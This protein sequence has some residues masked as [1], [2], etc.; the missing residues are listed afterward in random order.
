MA[1]PSTRTQTLYRLPTVVPTPE[2]MFDALGPSSVELL[3]SIAADVQQID[4]AGSPALWLSGQFEHAVASWC[5]HAATTTGL[6]VSYPSLQAAGLLLLA[7]DD[8]VYALGYGCGHRLIPDE[9]KDQSFGLRFAVRRLDPEQVQDLVRRL[10]GAR[11]RTDATV[12][13]GGLPVW[14][15]G[16]QEHAEI[17]RRIGGRTRDLKITFSGTDERPVKVEG[18][19]GLSMRFGVRPGD[20]VSD[21]REVARVCA[22]EAPYTAFEFVEYI[23]PVKDPDTRSIL[24]AEFSDLLATDEA[25]ATVAPV[26]PSS[27]ISDFAHAHSFTVKIGNAAARHIQALDVSEFLRRTR[28]QESGRRVSTLRE[29]HVRMYAD[30]EGSE[31]IGGASAIKWL[32]VSLP[33]GAQ[34]FFLLDGEWYEIDAH[35]LDIHQAQVGRLLSQ[36]PSLD[37]PPWDARWAERDYN[38]WVPLCR[39]GY[40]CLD[41]RGI[42]SALHRGNGVEICDLLA[43]DDELVLVKRAHG[44]APLSH[45]FGQGMVA[46][47]GLFFA[48]EARTRFAAAVREY[49]KGRI[50]R[51][52]FVPKK[53]VFAILLKDGQRLTPD[54]LFPFSQVTLASTARILEAQGIAVEVTGIPAAAL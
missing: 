15:L 8:V 48:P 23:Q 33:V 51:E 4:I 36:P 54:T 11:G 41:R 47:Q 12:I 1:R 32:E 20:L 18:G 43:P 49:G 7:V 27:L 35:Y 34:R 44:S 10:P 28:L 37:L 21:I 31:L 46:A 16:V 25:L 17:I 39:P 13:P 30:E 22:T 9:L 40:V 3:T 52:D 45:L 5:E 24:E 53:I 50:I 6:P 38:D 29:G 19:V 26:V 14:A 2:G 42:R